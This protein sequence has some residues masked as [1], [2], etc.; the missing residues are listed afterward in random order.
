M[1]TGALCVSDFFMN[2]SCVVHE[3]EILDVPAMVVLPR[4]E[5]TPE[6]FP[7]NR[8]IRNKSGQML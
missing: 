3:V 7:E 2:L 6:V 8:G 5:E 4:T 1:K